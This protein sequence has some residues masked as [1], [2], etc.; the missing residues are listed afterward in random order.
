MRRE[1]VS[2][3]GQWD[4]V[5]D[6]KGGGE[7]KGYSEGFEKQFGITVPFAAEC[8]ASGIGKEEACSSVWYARKFTLTKTKKKKRNWMGT[9]I[10]CCKCC[11]TIINVS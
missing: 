10:C 5:Y 11:N 4:F 3:D 7:K 1:W 6:P 8:A 9:R 2:L